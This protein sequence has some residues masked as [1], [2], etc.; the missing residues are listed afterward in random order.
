[1]MNKKPYNLILRFLEI[2][3][4]ANHY[5]HA[6]T[7]AM[8]F[9][10]HWYLEVPHEYYTMKNGCVRLTRAGWD[11]LMRQS[12]TVRVVHNDMWTLI[13]DGRVRQEGKKY[14]WVKPAY[15]EKVVTK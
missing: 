12:P 5:R 13:R 3:A 4:G 11:E 1:M 15:L 6:S 14:Y 9:G 2:V 7:I 8:R 10:T